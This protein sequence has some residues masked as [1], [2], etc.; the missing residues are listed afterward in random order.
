MDGGADHVEQVETTEEQS[1]R[2]EIIVT[3]G[4]D[5]TLA[6]KYHDMKPWKL[7]AA[8]KMLE[9]MGDQMVVENQMAMMQQQRQQQAAIDLLT[10]QPGGLRGPRQ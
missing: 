3:F 7:W 8:A 2:G 5:D 6:V 9:M 1:N 4:L 10:R